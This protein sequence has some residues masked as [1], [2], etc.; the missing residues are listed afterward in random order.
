MNALS[1]TFRLGCELRYDVTGPAAFIMNVSAVTNAAQRVRNE[2]LEIYPGTTVEECPGVEAEKRQHRF[3]AGPGSLQVRYSAEVEIVHTIEAS[4]LLTEVA[5]G[6]L[7]IAVVPYLYPSRYCES[8]M[9]VRLARQEFDG[10]PP[11]FQRVTAICNWI[12]DHVEYLHGA[13]NPMTSAYD[14]ATE[15]AGVCRDFAHL[16]IAFCRSMAIPARFVAGYA[17]NLVPRDFHACFEAYLGGAWY[18]FDATRLIP[19]SGFVR[20]GTGRDAADTSFATIFGPVTFSGMSIEMEQI[21]G[22]PPEYTTE[23]IRL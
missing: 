16:A 14:T 1:R 23:A 8:D 6:D 18:F 3:R 11:A 20:I 10:T 4:E 22:P 2:S 15:R 19:Q 21:G 12:H 5:T 9:L 17:W 13:T 7:P